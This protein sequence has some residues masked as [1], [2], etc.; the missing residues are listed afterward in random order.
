MVQ[1]FYLECHKKLLRENAAE[2]AVLLKKDGKFPLEKPCKIALYGSGA[3]RTI[4]GG[5]G[6][7]D[8]YTHDFNTCEQAL[9]NAGF[10][11]TTKSW[12]DRYD[13]ERAQSRKTFV[14]N[15]KKSAEEHGVSLF[16]ASF[17]KIEPEHD[18]KI[19]LD[20]G[21][22]TCIYVLARISGEGHD[23]K[24]EK[25]DVL[26]TDTEIKD[27][28]FL[29]DK[30]EQ[31]MLV[32]NVGGVVDLSPVSAVK[33]ILLLSQLGAVTGDVLADILLGK[34]NPSGKLALTWAKPEDYQKIG[35]FGDMN[36]TRYKEGVYIGYRYFDTANVEPLF[37]FG[38]GLSY[39]DFA[40]K[41]IKT[42]SEKSKIIVS[43]EI[44]N[45]GNLAG[46]EV[47]QLY[48]TPPKGK[49]DK[50]HQTLA[51]F[52]KTKVLK[53]GESQVL[54]LTFDMV[55]TASYSEENAQFILEEGSY[56]IRVG[57]SSR[58]TQPFC[59][60][61]LNKSVAVA[62][63][64]NCL[65]KPDFCDCMLVRDKTEDVS[66][67]PS[68]KLS[69][70]NIKTEKTIYGSTRYIDSL[71]RSMPDEVLAHF[72]VGAHLPE[73]KLSVL[74]NS[75]LHVAGAAGE[76]SNYIYEYTNGK[77]LTLA[78]GPAGLRLASTYIETS[79]GVSAVM[80]KY[81]DDL[82]DFVDDKTKTTMKAR[83]D[84]TPKE[85]LKEQYT[86]AIPIGTALA[87]SW[88]QEFA[89]LCGDIVGREM[90]RFGIAY[91]LAPAINIQRNIL[92]GRNFEYYSEDPFLTG[93]MAAAI[94]RG[95][96]N[97][98]NCG[99]TVKHFCANNQE[100]NRYNS[101]SI[102]SERA[103][104][105]I[106]LK[107]FEICIKESAPK[108]VMTSYNLLNG[109]HTSQ[110]RDLIEDIL[111]DE[112]GYCGI[113]MSDW[114]TTGQLHNK[115]SKHD[116]VYAHKV[117]AAGN[118]LMMPGVQADVDDILKALR[119]G[120]LSREALETCATRVYNAITNK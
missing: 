80:E 82:W 37:P 46:K 78:D 18:Y 14:E 84:D 51:A 62:K 95:V 6:S 98:K 23:R 55:D 109:E 40:T 16:I 44:K 110:R 26:L 28:L 38:Y 85:L 53:A 100:T 17:G 12:L 21:G 24:T 36:D 104:R 83:Y 19:P 70:E 9:K 48:V 116:T 87:Q 10:T 111:R 114:I 31:F 74:G 97:H 43:V 94:T 119:N 105:E 11:V 65:G 45:V 93:K 2:C 72:C 58:N 49:I 92:C 81:S 77:Y 47:V 8:V 61:E 89:E 60:V 39:S 20:G 69:A 88:N 59:V 42:H 101:N 96:Q 75:A 73:S 108:A 33:N 15:I 54:T 56:I 86:T 90:K 106:Y 7:G 91:W 41:I 118:D 79:D 67:L 32:L 71:V 27:I 113:V 5:T 50:P 29:N 102:V 22:E 107:A 25:G 1:N 76:T 34:A 63:L 99:V 30:F 66:A 103:M 35:D 57:N 115:N 112:W 117:I 68:F 120:L 3:R 13:E 4:K 64:K 52:A